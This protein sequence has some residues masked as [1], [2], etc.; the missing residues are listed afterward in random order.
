[1]EA[2]AGFAG[3]GSWLTGG[4]RERRDLSSSS[5][6]IFLA[7]GSALMTEGGDTSAPCLGPGAGLPGALCLGTW[8]SPGLGVQQ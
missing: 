7:L 6:P 1:M 5:A 8:Q 3:G 2:G 4:W